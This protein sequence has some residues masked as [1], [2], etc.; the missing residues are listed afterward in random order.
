MNRSVDLITREGGAMRAHPALDDARAVLDWIGS[1]NRMSFS[2]RDVYRI[3]H[4]RFP[5]SAQASTALS[6]LEDH[7]HIRRVASPA[8]PGRKTTAY[9]VHPD[10]VTR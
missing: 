1:G 10:A 8:R 2:E 6:V 3:M 5:T 4:R 9:E 7:G